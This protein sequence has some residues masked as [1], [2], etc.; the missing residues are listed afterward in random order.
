MTCDGSNGK[1]SCNCRRRFSMDK[2]DTHLHLITCRKCMLFSSTGATNGLR[3]SH[4]VVC[5]CLLPSEMENDSELHPW[6]F[7]ARRLVFKTSPKNVNDRLIIEKHSDMKLFLI[8]FLPVQ[9][10]VASL[11]TRSIEFSRA[12]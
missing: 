7:G 12:R 11:V 10:R 3:V 6:R 4:V 2:I 8:L 1:T 9:S 5:W